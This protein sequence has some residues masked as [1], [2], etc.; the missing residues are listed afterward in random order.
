VIEFPPATSEDIAF[1]CGMKMLH[2]T[3]VVQ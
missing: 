2:G 1:A 3:I